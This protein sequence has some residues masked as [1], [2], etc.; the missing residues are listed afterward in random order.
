MTDE[1]DDLVL[2]LLRDIRDEQIATQHKVDKL[3][4]KVTDAMELMTQAM[5][6]AAFAN[7][8]TDKFDDRVAEVEDPMQALEM[9]M[10]EL[11][12]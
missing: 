6:L 2:R 11:R 10:R 4:R 3:D 8:R 12:G 5:G 7:V 1:P 9:R